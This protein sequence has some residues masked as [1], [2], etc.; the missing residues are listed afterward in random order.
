MTDGEENRGPYNKERCNENCRENQNHVDIE[1][2]PRVHKIA[3]N[4][5]GIKRR[6][7]TGKGFGHRPVLYL[8]E[9]RSTC[10]NEGKNIGGNS[11]YKHLQTVKLQIFFKQRNNK[12][13]N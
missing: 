2:N 13:H 9:N 3:K 4:I 12:N 5:H 1:G 8:I 7:M 11:H 6:K 10:L